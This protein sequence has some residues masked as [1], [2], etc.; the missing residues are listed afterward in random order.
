[1]RV[2]T[3]NAEDPANKPSGGDPISASIRLPKRGKQCVGA[4]TPP[5]TKK[6]VPYEEFDYHIIK[7]DIKD[8][9]GNYNVFA[10]HLV[11]EIWP[12]LRNLWRARGGYRANIK[13]NPE[14]DL[15]EFGQ[16]YGPAMFN[17]EYNFE[18]SDEGIIL[19]RPGKRIY[20][21]RGYSC[22]WNLY[23][24]CDLLF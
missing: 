9:N 19:Q 15:K 17:A 5:T 6:D 10:N 21:G 4:S 11:N 23:D 22:P 7:E 3:S 18:I 1:M 2:T 16:Q 14:I 12:F 8:K 13:F 24:R 20:D